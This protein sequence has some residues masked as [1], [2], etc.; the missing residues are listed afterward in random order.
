MV[1]IKWYLQS[2]QTEIKVDL[3]RDSVTDEESR[4]ESK[5]ILWTIMA[6]IIWHLLSKQVEI[7]VDLYYDSN[8][9]KGSHIESKQ[10]L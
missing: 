3:Y 1:G 2:E 10:I 7:K 8:R 6:K 5:E 4:I 9:D